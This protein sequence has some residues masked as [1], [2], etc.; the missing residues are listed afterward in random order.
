MAVDLRFNLEPRKALEFFRGKGYA[1]SFGW[2]EV[3]QYEHDLAFTVAKMMNVDLLRD[4]R[5]AVDKAIAEGWTKQQFRDALEP[6]L[7]EAGWWGK[8]E[9]TDPDT[10]EIKQVQL[11]SP[12]RLQTI[13]E[14]NIQTSY[15]AGHWAQ[16]RQTK[17]DAPYLMYDAVND[18]QT[19][20]EHAAWDGLVLSADDPWWQA[21]FPPN[22]WG[23]RC[24]VIQLSRAQAEAMGKAE[25]DTAPA[26]QMR[27]YTNPRTG[28]TT[29]VPKG[30]GPG[31]AY[32]PGSSRIEM[33]RDLLTE[34]ER[35]FRDGK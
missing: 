9:M 21:H 5:M 23:C 32:A 3:W 8:A 13:F 18:A 6:R 11:G 31:W 15:A 12:R 26:V 30:V 16:I 4:V 25:P 7:V 27:D 20:P 24:G 29:Q 35:A 14:T 33:Q 1:T 19:R 28:E 10:G 2:Q 34:K 22:D 17:D